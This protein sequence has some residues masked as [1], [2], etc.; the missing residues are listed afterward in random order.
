MV[1]ARVKLS[2]YSN[3]VISVVKAKHDLNDKSEALNKFIEMYGPQEVE[4]KVR[5]SYMKKLLRVEKE[6][7]K[8]KIKP[9]TVQELRNEIER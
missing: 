4:P 6:I 9:Q 1:D 2:E 3:R 5:E 7:K 8:K